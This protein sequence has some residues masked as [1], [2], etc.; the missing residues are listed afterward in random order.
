MKEIREGK[1]SA[2]LAWGC[3]GSNFVQPDLPSRKSCQLFGKLAPNSFID[4][5]VRKGRE[6]NLFAHP[7]ELTLLI[8][9]RSVE[10]PKEF[11]DGK[12]IRGREGKRDFFTR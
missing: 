5:H 11:L 3:S 1:S 2:F 6:E 10:E 9:G 8:S 12:V 4:G 7:Q